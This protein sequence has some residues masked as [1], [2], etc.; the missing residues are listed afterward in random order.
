MP[1][2]YS[3]ADHPQ[4]Y[5][6]KWY[7]FLPGLMH[8]PY[9]ARHLDLANTNISHRLGH[10]LIAALEFIPVL[11]FLASLI[12]RIVIAVYN[13]FSTP[14]VETDTPLTEYVIDN[15]TEQEAP[16]T[17]TPVEDTVTKSVLAKRKLMKRLSLTPLDMPA[18]FASK[19]KTFTIEKGI[20][21][22]Q[23][24]FQLAIQE[25]RAIKGN[26]SLVPEIDLVPVLKNRQEKRNLAFTPKDCE[27]HGL[28]ERMEDAH[29]CIK[30]DQGRL[31]GVCDGHDDKGEIARYVVKCFK[32]EFSAILKASE[33]IREDHVREMNV[34]EAFDKM[35]EKIEAE[36]VKKLTADPTKGGG[37][38]MAISFIDDKT[39][40]IY[41][42]TLGDTEAKIYRNFGKGFKEDIKSIPLSVV[43]NWLH[44]EEY[45][46]AIK[47][48]NEQI[49]GKERLL[50]LG[51]NT[52][53]LKSEIAELRLN[54]DKF[55][56][57]KEIATKQKN[58]EL[59]FPGGDFGTNVSR[60]I[61]DFYM[62]AVRHNAFTTVTTLLPGDLVVIG[63]DGVWD[64][65]NESLLIKKVLEG[66]MSVAGKNF[67]EE[68]AHYAKQFHTPAHNDNITVVTVQVK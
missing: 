26:L 62:K 40:K 58:K 9:A 47:W 31:L 15:I 37:A 33:N 1:L 34:L 17:D 54:L 50:A 22:M 49:A 25:K 61:G 64:F 14:K 52:N 41:T 51:K 38:T 36:V 39:H 56:K 6:V 19:L 68:I 65:V 16:T 7:D 4:G 35:I 18:D 10:R 13:V 23:E 45:E 63:C 29:F 55:Q 66:N 27:I 2:N 28:R 5:D 11:G 43:R 3:L 53:T 46:H 59:R 42:A 20:E 32:E 60:A 30:I 8:S 48:F 21:T 44:P 12:E 24:N 67:A 57:Q